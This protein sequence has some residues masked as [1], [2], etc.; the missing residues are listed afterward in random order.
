MMH[1]YDSGWLIL[2]GL[3]FVGMIVFGIGLVFLL[4]WACKHLSER[5]LWQWGW[6]LAIIGFVV[7]LLTVGVMQ[8]PWMGSRGKRSFGVRDSM[9]DR[10]DSQNADDSEAQ[11]EEEAKG[12][13]L[14]DKLQAK[15]AACGDLS[16]A[17]FEL[18]GEYAMGQKLGVEHEGM[19]TMMKQM[20]GAG[21][22]E[23]MHVIV[24]KNATGCVTAGR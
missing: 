10:G 14:Y 22:E 23:R 15:Q 13:V 5:K 21:G 24:G 16:D 11:N 1:A 20:M 7:C 19:N 9:M 4:V 18:I 8:H 17:D 12:K 6:T 2:W 3:H